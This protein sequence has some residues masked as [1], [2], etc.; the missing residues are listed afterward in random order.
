[1]LFGTEKTLAVDLAIATGGFDIYHTFW[2]IVFDALVF[3]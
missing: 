1:M 3:G 2:V